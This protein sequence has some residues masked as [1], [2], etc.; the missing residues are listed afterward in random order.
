[1]LNKVV[2]ILGYVVLGVTALLGI[3]FFLQDAPKLQ[4]GLDA[5]QDMPQELKPEK[6]AEMSV[7]W[8]AGVFN[9]ALILFLLSGALAIGFAIVKFVL[10]VKDNP[11]S[12]IKTGISLAF[13]GLIILIAY[14]LSSDTIPAFLG[15]ENFD[16]SASESK[17]VETFLYTVY[18]FFGLSAVA[19]VY[20]EVSRI[21]R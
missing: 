17:W 9:W 4:A 14:S 21:W 19:L 16:I 2:K 11:K 3:L 8:S 13:I 12:A 5:I 18:L 10:S 6:I 1:M 7:D 20:A 15:A